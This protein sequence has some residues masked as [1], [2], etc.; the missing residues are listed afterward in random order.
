MPKGQIDVALTEARRCVDSV[1]NSRDLLDL[2]GQVAIQLVNTFQTGGKVLIA[3]NGGSL[4]DAMH[5]AEEWTGRFRT[6]RRPYPVIALSDP[7]HLT[8]VANDYGFEHVFS[9]MVTALARP[10]DIVILLST[11]GNSR[12]L[13]LAAEAAHDIGAQVVGFLGRGGGQL[14]PMC[15]LAFIAPG[16]TADRIQEI[17]MLCLHILT[18][19][20]ESELAGG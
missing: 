6:D 16:E 10:G 14:A 20:T 13:L 8:C 12:N 5:F 18:E 3:G 11:S 4:A 7:T 19:V 17:H 1:L 9:R 15:D 2:L